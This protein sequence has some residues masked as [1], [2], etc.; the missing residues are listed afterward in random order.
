MYLKRDGNL[1]LPQV[2]EVDKG[3]SIVAY[4]EEI[5]NDVIQFYYKNESTANLKYFTNCTYDEFLE[6]FNQKFT[7]NNSKFVKN[8]KNQII[9]GIIASKDSGKIWIDNFTVHPEYDNDNVGEIL[10]NET[11][12]SLSKECPKENI[13]IYLNRDCKKAIFSCEKNGFISFEFW[14]DMILER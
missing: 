8:S 7:I 12:K 6:M 2:N 5:L 1:P 4:S 9:A 10:L 11:I 13:Y 14:T 3:L